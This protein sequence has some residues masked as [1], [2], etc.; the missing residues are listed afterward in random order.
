MVVG[1]QTRPAHRLARDGVE[2]HRVV[3]A[4]R[5]RAELD[6]QLE[7]VVV[8]AHRRGRY[9]PIAG[10][11]RRGPTVDVVAPIAP[12]AAIRTWGSTPEERSAPY[13]CDEVLPDADDVLYRAVTVRA[14]APLMFR[15]LCQLRHA[16]YSYDLLDNFGRRSPQALEP[17]TDE[18]VVGQRMVAIFRLASFE[19]DRHLTL[20][21]RAHP[22]FGDVAVTYRVEPTGAG[23]CRLVVKL[24]VRYPR[25]R[26]GR[27]GR[28]WLPA[29]DLVMM[30]RQLLNL[31]ALA[32]RDA[33]A[34]GPAPDDPSGRVAAG[35]PASR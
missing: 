6:G 34:A 3:L 7:P 33:H 9:C 23:A 18:L 15:W 29:G 22:V 11:A 31:R 12:C 10:D 2:R 21:A 30:R 27:L 32:E 4:V 1:V 26:L 5:A 24:A 19:R 20:L 28:W 25:H 8:L 14:P 16:P 35:Q 13:A 17:G